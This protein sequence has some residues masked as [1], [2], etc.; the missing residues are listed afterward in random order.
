M[1]SPKVYVLHALREDSRSTTISH[2][3]CFGRYLTD[4]QVEY[5]N[6]FGKIPSQTKSDL[7]IVTYELVALRN[8]P[9]WKDLVHRIAPI[10]RDAKL[11][12]VMPQDDYSSCDVLDQFV[13]EQN[14]DFVFTPITRDLEQLYPKSSQ[15]DVKFHEAFTGYFEQ[16]DWV[17]LEQFSRPYEKRTVD[18]GQRV[19]HLPPQLGEIA[20]RKGQLAVEFA[21]LASAA[22]FFCDV[23]TRAEDVFVG[24]DWWKF[25]GNSKFTVSRK[26]GASMADPKGR[27][28][29]K[30]RRYQ[31]RHPN[32]TMEQ[33]ARRVSFKGGREGDFSAISP[34]LFEAAALG[35]CQI[36][37]P[38]H[39]VD[40]FE[41]WI[42][43]IP[44]SEDFSNIDDVFD[45]MRDVERCKGI[46]QA[47]QNLL[48]R[49]NAH[50]YSSFVEL[51]S[52]VV[53]I[54][55]GGPA[56]QP[57]HD[58]SSSFDG[59]FGQKSESIYWVQD[60]VRRAFLKRKIKQSLNSLH[61]GKLLIL[62][63]KDLDWSD[64][65]E[66]DCRSLITWLESFQN[67]DLIIESYE[68]P[69]RTMSSLVKH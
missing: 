59:E 25:L 46:V 24:D 36:L 21:H 12:V 56:S 49:S 7:A 20:G 47:S 38:S 4:C 50:S 13:V 8:L 65:N 3:A 9:I 34:R 1:I 26:G 41:P 44:L 15:R 32:A 40:G 68:L 16:S 54:G 17:Y 35:V 33:I 19:R 28:A 53:Q 51:F 10:L 57:L 6:V 63:S 29:D 42:H 55:K 48:L 37:E 18:I 14:F 27:L 22:G 23:S 67:G 58:S 11:R 52:N 64:L 45:V 30:V 60:Y 5:V 69:W 39:Y 43:Y 2:T 62:D 66:L 31:L 61:E